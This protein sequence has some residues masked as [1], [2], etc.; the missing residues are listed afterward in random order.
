M[1]FEVIELKGSNKYEPAKV[2]FY[3]KKRS[4]GH[5]AYSIYFSSS[6]TR[7]YLTSDAKYV[8]FLYDKETKILLF[9]FSN[10]STVNSRKLSGQYNTERLWVSAASLVSKVLDSGSQNFEV[11]EVDGSPAIKLSV[12]ILK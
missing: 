3:C 12:D 9:K 11:F 4:N 8:T 10:Q 6:F 7:K 1:A 5:K 2:Y